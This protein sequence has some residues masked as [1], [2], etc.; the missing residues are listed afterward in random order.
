MSQE[1]EIYRVLLELKETAGKTEAGIDDI[2][3]SI[4]DHAIA[5]DKLREEHIALKESHNSLKGKVLW[6]SGF[7]GTVFGAFT[8][9]L[10]I[11]W[12]KIFG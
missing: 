1:H 4:E 12:N 10:K 7:V 8:A 3:K 2:K 5:H 6:V 9:W 11:E